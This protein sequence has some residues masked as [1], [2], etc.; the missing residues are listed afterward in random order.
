MLTRNEAKRKLKKMGL[1][2]RKASPLL[3]VSYP[4]LCYVLNGHR[5][6]GRLMRAIAALSH[7]DLKRHAGDALT[8]GVES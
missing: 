5:D 2:Y 8:N 4:H 3:G 6:S 1:S 7:E